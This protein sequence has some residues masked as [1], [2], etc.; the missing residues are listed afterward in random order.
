VRDAPGAW[1]GPTWQALA[2]NLSDPHYYSYEYVS[3]GTGT[4]AVFTARALGDLD[5]DRTYSTFERSGG[6]TPTYEVQGSAG[7][8]MY[9]ETE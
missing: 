5:G 8:W 6:A 2:F 4:T 3:S 7:V 9:N 1:E